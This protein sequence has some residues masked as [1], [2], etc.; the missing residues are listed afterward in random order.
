MTTAIMTVTLA[1]TLT[2]ALA[3]TL[4]PSLPPPLR[5]ALQADSIL[6]LTRRLA[7]LVLVLAVA[8]ALV[9]PVVAK[10]IATRGV[11]LAGGGRRIFVFE[12]GDRL[13][14]RVRQRT[15]RAVGLELL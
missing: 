10:G 2:L 9:P 3:L 8:R 14:R 1:L 4:T 15:S 12:L 7:G 6:A 13:R 5:A 11:V